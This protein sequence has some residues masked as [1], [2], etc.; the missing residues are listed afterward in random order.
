MKIQATVT[1]HYDSEVMDADH[2]TEQEFF[3]LVSRCTLD[4]FNGGVEF[5]S[6]SIDME[7]LK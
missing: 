1:L 7:V 4:D 2:L 6:V 5:D 3:Q